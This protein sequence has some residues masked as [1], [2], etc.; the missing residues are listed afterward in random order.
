MGVSSFGTSLTLVF[1]GT[2]GHVDHGKVCS[3]LASGSLIESSLSGLNCHSL[4]R[5]RPPT[6]V[7]EGLQGHTL[8][9]VGSGCQFGI[10]CL[11]STLGWKHQVPGGL[12]TCLSPNTTKFWTTLPSS[13]LEMLLLGAKTPI[14]SGGEFSVSILLAQ[15]C[16]S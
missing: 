5:S 8:E 11:H 14:Y 16:W 7:I 13:A 4:A 15:F 12:E 2:I 6:V 9:S 1:S 10:H 3:Q